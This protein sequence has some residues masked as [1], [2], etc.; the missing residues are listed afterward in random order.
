MSKYEQEVLNTPVFNY[1]HL[2]AKKVFFLFCFDLV[3]GLLVMGSVTQ[4]D[5]KL[6]T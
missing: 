5:L 6:P 1:K 2:L 4:A 3:L